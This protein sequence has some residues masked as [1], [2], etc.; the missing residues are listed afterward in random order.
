M[1]ARRRWGLRAR[2]VLAFV[3][4]ALLGTAITTIYASA[5]LT[6][7]LETSAKTRLHNS[8]SHF[9]DVAAVVSE[10]G[11]WNQQ[12]IETLHHLAQLEFL[13][14]SLS[15]ASGRQ[16]LSHPPSEPVQ[17]GAAVTAPVTVG[18]RKIGTVVVSR[19]D[20]RLFTVEEIRLREELL[21]MHLVAGIVSA[22]IAVLVALYLAVTLSRPLRSI[23]AGA[24]AMSAGDLD[25]RVPETGDDEIAS[26]AD[27]LNRLAETLQQEETLRKESVADLAHELRTPV[28]GILA[29]VEAA[30]DGV[31]DDEGAN[32]SA[33]HD[34]ALRLA[35]LLDDLSALAEAERP[36]L[37]LDAE[38]VDL[39]AIARSQ[40][41]AFAA[42]FA[43][44]RIVLSTDL[45]P[46]IVQ[47]EPKRL[48]QIVVNLLSNALRY[49]D[50]EGS[51]GV[52]VSRRGDQA[53]L[54]VRDTGIGIAA[55]DLP[56]VF[57]RFWR[58]DK[59]RSRDTGG[60]GIGLS[61][62]KELVQAHNGA[63]TVESAPGQGSTFRVTLPLSEKT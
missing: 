37:L 57:T 3:A 33:M 1:S 50:A 47:G 55:E 18:S 44:R 52:V 9:G 63:I 5:S 7:H 59:S 22:A 16:V 17:E 8:A 46:A 62:V 49:T 61:I 29:R 34:E 43:D 10:D 27:A 41:S 35:R 30:Q 60:A 12:A 15:D 48:E 42:V 38:P 6:S 20:G 28:M 14:V 58:S 32:L 4:V 56:R 11:R 21:S 39:A 53:L 23:R 45:E 36:G 2:L 13:A 25:A 26:V 51:V 54:E 19:D 31:L 24:D 40:A